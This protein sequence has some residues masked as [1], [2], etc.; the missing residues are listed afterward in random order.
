MSPLEL[1]RRHSNILGDALQILLRQINEALLLATIGASGLAF[2][3]Q[4]SH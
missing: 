4:G 1:A 3:S 2:K